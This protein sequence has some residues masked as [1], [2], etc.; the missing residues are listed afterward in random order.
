MKEFSKL[1]KNI[2]LDFKNKDHLIQ[3]F[4]HR[5]FLNE[6]PD[7]KLNHNERLEFLGDAVLELVVT[8]YLYKEYPEESE[9]ILTNWRAS[10]VNTKKLVEVANDLKL[11][12]YLLLSKGENK[13]RKRTKQY[14]LADTFEALIGAVFLDFGYKRCYTFIEKNLLIRLPYI[15]ENNL[16]RDSKSYFQEKSQEKLGITPIYKV[17]KDWGPDHKKK[18]L[19]G[20]FL[21]KD[22]VAQGEGTSKQEAEERAAEKALKI[23]NWDN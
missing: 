15:I 5:S 22:L 14:I 10:L 2:G 21:N 13:D 16:F 18:F 1:E 9:G 8:E 17:L 6:N 12:D 19:I 11:G 3:A 23:K 7:F 20:V 4:C